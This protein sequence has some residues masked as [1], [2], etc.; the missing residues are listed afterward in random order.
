MR[1]EDGLQGWHFEC[2][3][4][5]FWIEL[6]TSCIMYRAI[7]CLGNGVRGGLA[8]QVAGKQITEN[9]PRMQMTSG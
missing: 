3:F 2:A 1:F 6:A 9:R 8:T 5:T 7:I 4:T